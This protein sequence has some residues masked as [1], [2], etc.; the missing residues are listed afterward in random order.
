M[1][2]SRKL[3][4]DGSIDYSDDAERVIAPQARRGRRSKERKFGESSCKNKKRFSREAALAAR[5]NFNEKK[6]KRG[7]GLMIYHCRFCKCFHLGHDR[8]R[9]TTEVKTNATTH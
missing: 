2:D 3:L 8:K 7:R 6:D 1:V 9:K 5:D 4:S